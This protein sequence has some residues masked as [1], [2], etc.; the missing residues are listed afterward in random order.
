M[1][2]FGEG[3]Y[4]YSYNATVDNLHELSSYLK[5]ILNY[6]KFLYNR[7]RDEDA[8]E[9]VRV[10]YNIYSDWIVDSALNKT[11][12][13]ADQMHDVKI[14]FYELQWDV[15][16]IIGNIIL[17]KDP[18]SYIFDTSIDV[19]ELLTQIHLIYSQLGIDVNGDLKKMYDLVEF[20]DEYI[21]VSLINIYKEERSGRS[22]HIEKNRSNELG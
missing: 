11:D 1:M 22:Q 13:T 4:E 19:N 2:M 3:V 12:L 6:G 7:T 21:R 8:I 9:A 5:T 14:L 10:E 15:D 20:I 18:V 16:G 17:D